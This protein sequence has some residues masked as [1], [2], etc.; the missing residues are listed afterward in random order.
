MP[1]ADELEDLWNDY[2]G[3]TWVEVPVAELEAD[4]DA[5]SIA[6]LANS[7]EVPTY[8]QTLT[9]KECKYLD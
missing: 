9:T 5:P 3:K 7:Y 8:T 6:D 2:F 1:T 4:S